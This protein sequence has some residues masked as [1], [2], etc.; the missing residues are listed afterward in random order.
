MSLSRW[1]DSG[2]RFEFDGHRIYTRTQGQGP[3]A[4]LLLHGLPTGSWDYEAMW[5]ALTRRFAHVIAFDFLGCGFSDKPARHRY[6]LFE[7]ADLALALLRARGVER[8]HLITHDYGVSIA[9]E[10]LARD[11]ARAQLQSTMPQLLSCIFL[12][13]GLMHGA[14]RY[15]SALGV[16][17]GPLGPLYSR[18]IGPRRFAKAF[19]RF[20]G[21]QTR[22]GQIEQHD[23]WTLLS[24]QQGC[25][26]L[27][28][29]LRY[30]DE[31]D[32]QRGRYLDTLRRTT[33]PLRLIC[34][35]ADPYSGRAMVERYRRALAQADVVLLEQIGHLPHVEAPDRVLR[36]VH[37]FH[38]RL[39]DAD[40]GERR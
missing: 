8:V 1:R 18:M 30:I 15:F 13:G 4:L 26:V 36:A 24:L 34:G 17:R 2:G 5:P 23:Y 37:A 33:V 21:P 14:Y 35:L 9:L 39:A 12:S 20:F 32:E 3:E 29:L 19:A 27:P 40:T 7:Q 25:R 22:P 16:L 38:D 11:L 28:R 6:S 31:R 10:L